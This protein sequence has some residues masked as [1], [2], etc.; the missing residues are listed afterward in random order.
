MLL[1]QLMHRQNDRVSQ[2]ER[3]WCCIIQQDDHRCWQG[4]RCEHGSVWLMEFCSSNRHIISALVQQHEH[5][6]ASEASPRRLCCANGTFISPSSWTALMYLH[7][8]TS[9]NLTSWDPSNNE[10]ACELDLQRGAPWGEKSH[11]N[12][13][14]MQSKFFY[15]QGFNSFRLI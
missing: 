10:E 7:S 13:I 5:V 14:K 2:K 12:R 15:K 9:V 1:L 8:G 4:S 3:T 11:N 6:G